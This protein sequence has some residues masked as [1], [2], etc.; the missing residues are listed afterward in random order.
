ML[1]FLLTLIAAYA[2]WRIVR[3]EIARHRERRFVRESL[4]PGAGIE[5]RG[6]QLLAWQRE[7][8]AQQ[9]AIDE[10]IRAIL[11]RTPW[12]MRGAMREHL[13]KRLDLGYDI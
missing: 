9:K 2:V 6:E 1:Q 10:R 5:L 7:R 8:A 13:R 4:R 12:R 3:Y 11:K